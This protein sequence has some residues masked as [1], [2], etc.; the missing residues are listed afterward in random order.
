M[1]KNK[2]MTGLEPTVF[3]ASEK[4]SRAQFATILYRAS[5]ENKIPFTARFPDVAD[6]QFYSEQ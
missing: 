5:G 6:G 2:I 4:V 1:Y 3:G